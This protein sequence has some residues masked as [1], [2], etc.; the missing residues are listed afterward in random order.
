MCVCLVACESP[1]MV[2]E[3]L[4]VF[5]LGG[6]PPLSQTLGRDEPLLFVV[7]Q[8]QG[9]IVLDLVTPRILKPGGGYRILTKH[10]RAG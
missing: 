10:N 6:L 2:A 3:S 7:D 8:E 9:I 5:R 1:F 4:F